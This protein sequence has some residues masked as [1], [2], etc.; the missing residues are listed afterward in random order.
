MNNLYEKIKKVEALIERAS[1]E[2]ERLSAINAK[3]RLEKTMSQ[4]KELEYRLST[5][6]NWHKKLLVALCRKHGLKPYRYYRQKYTTVMVRVTK[7][8]LDNYLWEEYLEYSRILTS[9]VDDIT[10]DLISKIYKVEDEV[11]I[12][13]EIE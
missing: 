5:P 12:H 11:V 8:Y 10:F 3:L 13:G 7:D 1:S 6:D 9:L 4:E 2:G